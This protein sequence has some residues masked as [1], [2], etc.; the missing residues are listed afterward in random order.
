MDEQVIRNRGE[1]LSVFCSR[2][3]LVE[4]LLEILE[5][6]IKAVEPRG[7]VKR[8]LRL[9][10]GALVA[11]EA[12]TSLRGVREVWVVAVGKAAPGMARGAL[13]L[14]G[15]LAR[16]CVVV[17]PRE[18]DFSALRG[19][20]EI[21][22]SSH[23]IPDDSGLRAAET[24]LEEL[25]RATADT[26]ILFLLSG[27]ASALLPAP[28]EGIRLEDEAETTRLLL[29]AGAT[30]TD[31]NTVRKHISSVK[32]GLL[33]RAMM[34]ARVLSLILSDVPCDRLDVV[35]SGPTAPDP[36]TFRDALEVL[37]R[38]GVWERAPQRVRERL[39]RGVSGL[40]EETPKPGDPVFQK[41][42]NLVIGGVGDALEAAASRAVSLGYEA[43]ILSR[44]FEGE[45]SSMGL[46]MGSVARELERHGGTVYLAGGESTVR[47]RG[48]GR[49]GRNQELAL[50]ALTKMQGCRGVM[51]AALGTDGVDG[52]TDAAGA[53][54]GE[55]QLVRAE[56]LSI[57]PEDYLRNNDSYSFFKRVGGHIVTGPT[58]TNVGDIV[59]TISAGQ[60]LARP[61]SGRTPKP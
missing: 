54:A 61:A 48:R 14:L 43:R 29:E 9:E 25:R 32:G 56:E 40:L 6:S 3:A 19:L 2:A 38:Y 12:A 35:G 15:G 28:A 8:K 45:A 18:S 33:A 5:A 1:I 23:P 24:L 20:A 58:G 21:L 7:I 50:A 60:P 44:C 51:L 26:L 41:V 57:R 31:L 49:G 10:G 47:V 13:E 17:A 55:E 34:P 30:I 39:E 46:F 42:T 27:G 52:P 36:T 59:V 53:V 37:V 11:G 4:D 16:R 22:P